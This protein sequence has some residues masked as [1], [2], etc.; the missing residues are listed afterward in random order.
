MSEPNCYCYDCGI[1]YHQPGP[2]GI[3]NEPS[4]FRCGACWVKLHTNGKEC[5][6]E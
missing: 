5:D 6:C 3:S 1:H 4:L 2:Y